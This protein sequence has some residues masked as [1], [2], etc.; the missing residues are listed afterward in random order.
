MRVTPAGQLE[1]EPER[2]TSGLDV[3]SLSVSP[4]GTLIAYTSY[5]PS[6]NIWSVAIPE[7]GVASVADAQQVTF[8][9][10]KIEKV[11][12][13]PDGQWLA[14]DSARNGQ[15]DIWKVRIPGGTPE[16]V[17]RGPNHKFVND[18]SPDGQEILFHTIRDGQ[19]DVFVVSADGLRTEPVATGP[20][21]EEHSAWGPDSNTVIFDGTPEGSPVN[22]WEAYVVT[23]P[24]RGAAWST[25]RRITTR[26]SSDPKWSPD[27]RLIAYCVGAQL[28]VIAPDGSGERVI[29]DGSRGDG[30]DPSYP[31]WSRDSRTIYFK[32][33][34]RDRHSTIWSVPAA[35]G[36]PR[37]L[38]RFD[39]PSR[40][41]L[42]REFASDGR[43]FYFTIAREESDVWT[44]ELIT[45]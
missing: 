38:V 34:D 11:A 22:A 2:L 9:T 17:T 19:R 43:R 25:P 20:R 3:H 33:Y 27:S 36:A 45:K 42:R 4:Q 18:W 44:M 1:G 21:E 40:R 23:R 7:K 37:L 39:D 26:G 29:V 16:Q 30:L 41:S 13:S 35:G 12:V 8:G 10:E 24:R 5:S 14:Y 31:V 6:A 28:R 15:A 32:A